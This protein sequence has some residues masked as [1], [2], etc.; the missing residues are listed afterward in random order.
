MWNQCSREH[1]YVYS[2]EKVSNIQV[3][4]ERKRLSGWVNSPAEAMVFIWLLKRE[5]HDV[6]EKRFVENVG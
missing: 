6:F 1:N 4:Y 2:A 5:Q 3:L